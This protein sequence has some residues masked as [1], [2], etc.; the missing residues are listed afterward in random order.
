MG[1]FR[2][3]FN[4]LIQSLLL[5]ALVPFLYHYPA[6]IDWFLF[7]FIFSSHC[8]SSSYTGR[9][10]E[11]VINLGSY[12][13][14]GFAENTGS[15]ADAAAEV[16]MKYGVGVAST[17]QEIG[18]STRQYRLTCCHS[19]RLTIGMCREEFSMVNKA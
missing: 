9:V 10:V 16:T 2:L 4:Y 7:V 8:L 3:A 1:N 19:W 17:R 5:I 13:Y 12:N 18:T 15:C 11:D 14:L 6:L